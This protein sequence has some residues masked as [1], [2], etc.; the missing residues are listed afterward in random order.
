[1][2][3]YLV[4][5]FSCT[6]EVDLPYP[7]HQTQPVLNGLLHPD[8][9]ITISLTKSIAVGRGT[10]FTAIDHAA[11]Q[12]YENTQPLGMATYLGDGYYGWD[13]H[14][15]PGNTYRLEASVPGLPTILAEDK[16]PAQPQIIYSSYL[17]LS[18]TSLTQL[19]FSINN[20]EDEKEIYWLSG[21]YIFYEREWDIDN[22]QGLIDSTFTLTRAFG[23]FA[24]QKPPFFID[25]FNRTFHNY[26]NTYEFYH[27]LRM[28]DLLLNAPSFDFSAGFHLSEILDED[29]EKNGIYATVTHA[30]EHYDKYLKSSVIHYLNADLGDEP[31]P[32]SSPVKIYSN[33]ENGLGIFAAY[34]AVTIRLEKQ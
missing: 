24:I 9:T 33:V 29:D 21:Y 32:F 12:L 15:V 27:Y 25:D 30:S 31:N 17:K 6:Q 19:H 7:T 3:L 28:D 8:S 26:D 10:E 22:R 4:V 34:N 16:V 20:A 5:A 23:H 13:Y 11:V 2:L 1:M 18:N 14:P